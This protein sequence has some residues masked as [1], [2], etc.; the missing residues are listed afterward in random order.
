MIV[1]EARPSD[2]L[3][4]A[5]VHVRC[6]REAYVGIVPQQTLDTMSVDDRHARWASLLEAEQPDAAFRVFVAEAD[7]GVVGFASV[8]K[9]RDERL[10][11]DG[12]AGEFAAIYILADF[13]GTGVAQ[14]L[15]VAMCR[16]L[17][18][19][20]VETA[21]VWV[22]EQN[23]RAR[24]F[25]EKLDGA[26]LRIEERDRGDMVLREVAYGWR[27]LKQDWSP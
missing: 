21:S 9:Q 5:K 4:I 27:R 18:S 7:G 8:M 19:I 2:A 25:Y 13:Y 1:R 26:F 11:E 16:H 12:F 14:Q 20:G 24:R 22:L 23:V 10:A 3:S 17:E 15:M 6:W